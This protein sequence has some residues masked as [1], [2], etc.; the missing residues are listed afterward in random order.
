LAY[1]PQKAWKQSRTGRP[2]R[3]VREM[4]L[5]ILLPALALALIGVAMVY[6]A[7]Y[8]KNEM[9][10]IYLK[11]IVWVSVG[12]M[13]MLFLASLNFQVLV[14][15]YAHAAYW[16]LLVLL[17]VLLAAGDQI[18]GSKRWL[19]FG[20]FGFQPSEFAKVAT[21]LVLAKYLAARQDRVQEWQTIFGAFLIAGIPTALILKEPDLGTALVFIPLVFVLLYTSG[22]PVRRLFY[23]AGAGVLTSP[24]VWMLLKDYQRRRLIVFLNPSSDTLGAGY[25]VIQSKIAI[26]SGRLLGKGW[27][28][29]TQGQLRFVPEHHTDFI[30]SVMAEEWGFIGVMVLLLLFTIL[31]LQMLRVARAAREMSGSLTAVGLTIILFT[32]I[33]VNL[34]VATGI[35]PVTGMTLP[36]ISYGGSSMIVCMSMLGI[37]MS[38]WSGRKVK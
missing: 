2:L 25:N 24:L 35:L 13:G 23:I 16:V 22:V 33:I 18:S 8:A 32:Q 31:L 37:L 6:S 28:S 17:A 5:T 11:Q 14:E 4:D 19:S 30:F 9:S 21:T 20:P 29:G 26:G 1:L 12:I 10:V 7:T 15:R 27:L 36:F 3:M 34:G 38:I